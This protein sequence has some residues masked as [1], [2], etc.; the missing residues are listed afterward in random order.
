MNDFID[1][2]N[3]VPLSQ[4]AV[5]IFVVI[6][7]IA[8]AFLMTVYTPMT[9]EIG[10]LETEATSLNRE[11]DRLRQIQENQAEVV[12]RLE[13]LN[14]QLHI[15]RE[16]LP[17]SAEIPSLLQR[18]HNQAQ[19][20]G[21]S[22]NRFQRNEDVDRADFVEIPVAISMK[23]NFDEMTNFFYFVGRMT[24]IV[25]IRQIEIQRSASGMNPDGELTVSAQA[26]TYRWKPN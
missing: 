21:L 4:K 17:E 12:A 25:N 16:K 26:T 6:V 24:R 9:E 5:G 19:T 13:A 14:A 11:A 23:G 20:A 22:I 18:I 2:F 3:S 8:V 15:A 7:V 1:K 10:S